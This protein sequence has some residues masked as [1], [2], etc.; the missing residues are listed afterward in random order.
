MAGVTVVTDST[1]YLPPELR[2]RAGDRRQRPRGAQGAQDL[3]RDRHAGV[4]EA[5]GAHRRGQRLDRVDPEG[6]ADPHRRERDDAGGARAD[7]DSRLR[8]HG[9]L[10]ATAARIRR[11]RLVRAA[12]RGARRVRAARRAL[13]RDLRLRADDRQRDRPGA[14]GPH[15]P[16]S[17]RGGR[18]P[19]SLRPVGAAAGGGET[20]PMPSA[21]AGVRVVLVVVA[22]AVFL[23]LIYPGRRPLLWLIVAIFLAAALSAPVNWLARRMRRG[24][25]V[26]I[27]F[28]C[29]LGIPI[30][31]IALIVPPVITEGTEFA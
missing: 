21:G 16:R 25:A 3:V 31:L 5:R 2:E 7:F 12:H 19:L 10:R 27:V 6:E 28:L 24:F 17:P 13:Q 8:A 30:L 9:R 4:P 29:L 22:G 14:G 1:S 20:A 26:A 18:P 15:G 11:G 23:Y